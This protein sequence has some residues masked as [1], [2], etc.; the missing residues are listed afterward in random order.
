[1]SWG[2]ISVCFVLPSCIDAKLRTRHLQVAVEAIR[3]A[4]ENADRLRLFIEEL[5]ALKEV[6]SNNPVINAAIAS[7]CAK[8]FQRGVYTLA[9]LIDHCRRFAAKVRKCLFALGKYW[10]YKQ[11]CY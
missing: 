8:A 5:A 10:R 9:Q 2:Y 11:I 1:M 7:I 6:S 3:P 4:F